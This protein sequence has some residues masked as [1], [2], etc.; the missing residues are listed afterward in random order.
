M[1]KHLMVMVLLGLATL[2]GGMGSYS[3]GPLASAQC[4]CANPEGAVGDE[5]CNKKEG[6]RMKCEEP[7]T[8]ECKW[9]QTDDICAEGDPPCS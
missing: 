8:D 7:V 1:R 4:K 9:L 6:K 3:C 2:L 5:C